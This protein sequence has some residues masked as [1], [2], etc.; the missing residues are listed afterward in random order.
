MAGVQAPN[1]AE[2]PGVRKRF[3]PI[4][5]ADTYEWLDTQTTPPNSPSNS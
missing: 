5:A 2:N 1:K 4:A 3:A